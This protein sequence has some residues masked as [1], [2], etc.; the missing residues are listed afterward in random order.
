MSYSNKEL[1]YMAKHLL[2]ILDDPDVSMAT[3]PRKEG[4]PELAVIK[5]DIFMDI[6]TENQQLK[7]WI[8]MAGQVIV[9]LDV[10]SS[11]L[12]SDIRNLLMMAVDAGDRFFG[13]DKDRLEAVK[14]EFGNE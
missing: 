13:M 6:E 11:T 9:S 8:H 12:G 2:S 14:K 1:K 4:Y 7:K 3:V 5:K 10:N